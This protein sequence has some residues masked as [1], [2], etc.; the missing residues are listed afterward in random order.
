MMRSEYIYIPSSKLTYIYG[1]SPFLI[2]NSTI[3]GPYS[4]AM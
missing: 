4:I 2:G 1:K 3:N